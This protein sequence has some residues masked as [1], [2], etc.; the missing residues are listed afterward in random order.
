[1]A[2]V[3]LRQND[4]ADAGTRTGVTR[5]NDHLILIIAGTIWPFP[6]LIDAT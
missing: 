2:V 6:T 1:M 4:A 3:V 5:A